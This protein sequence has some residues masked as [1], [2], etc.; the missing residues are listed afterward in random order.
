M[1][2]LSL[3][4]IAITIFVLT[5]ASLL[6]PLIH[7]SPI[8]PAIIVSMGLG[9]ATIDTLSLQGQ[10]V[11]LLL[12][13]L[14]QFSP[15][16]RD[17]V[18]RH[19]AGHF[20]AAHVLEVPILGYALTAWEALKQR[21]NA[22]GG[23]MFDWPQLE[24]QLQQF[25]ARQQPPQLRQLLDRYCILWMA[26]RAAE[27][28]HYEQ[29]IGGSDDLERFRFALSKFGY[30]ASEV[31]AKERWALLQAKTLLQ[32]HPV[33]YEDLVKA[34]AE[35]QSVQDCQSILAQAEKVT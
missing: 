8:V 34:M 30:S 23:V 28:L 6:G 10:G 7:L 21:Q 32:T 14:A 22:Y 31:A 11:T 33:S 24:E 9:L 3:S 25:D 2:E 13:G 17:R 1:S 18:L 12:D 16:H 35:R 27:Q 19:E 20:L 15:A 29:S 5:M 4:L 26:G